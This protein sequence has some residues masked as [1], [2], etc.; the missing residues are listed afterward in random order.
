[1]VARRSKGSPRKTRR[2]E[3]K[4]V[5]R[6]AATREAC[7]ITFSLGDVPFPLNITGIW[8]TNNEKP[9]G[10]PGGIFLLP[11]NRLRRGP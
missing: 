6:A 1:M 10:V 9:T 7:S 5:L 11:E 3:T 2:S 4:A 8:S